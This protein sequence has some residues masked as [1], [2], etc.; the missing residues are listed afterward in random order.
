VPLSES[1]R[2]DALF[3]FHVV[4]KIFLL[5]QQRVLVPFASVPSF[6][7]IQNQVSLG[8]MQRV[9]RCYKYVHVCILAICLLFLSR[10]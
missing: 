4:R 5:N 10:E 2:L 8:M 1:K 6:Q 3:D 7:S 9:H